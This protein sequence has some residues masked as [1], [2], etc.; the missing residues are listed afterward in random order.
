M[1]NKTKVIVEPTI[2]WVIFVNKVKYA[3]YMAERR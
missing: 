2:E 1:R 3:I